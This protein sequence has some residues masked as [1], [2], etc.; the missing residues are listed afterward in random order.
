ME[1]DGT[2]MTKN[3]FLHIFLIF[4]IINLLGCK[5][6]TKQNA[7][8]EQVDIFQNIIKNNELK[9]IIINNSVDYF[10]YKGTPM[11]FHYELIKEYT[12]DFGVSLTLIVAP[13]YEN[14]LELLES[15]EGHMLASNV[16]ITGSRKKRMLFSEPFMRSNP[17]LVQNKESNKQ[18]IEDW[19]DTDTIKITIPKESASER[20]IQNIEENLG[21]C[22][23]TEFYANVDQEQLIDMVAEDS[24]AST[25]ADKLVAKVAKT[26]YPQLDISIN[27]GLPHNMA[28]AINKN[29]VEL[30][31]NIND[32]INVFRKSK[33]YRTLY[34]KYF[35][36]KKSIVRNKEGKL[37]S[38]KALSRYDKYI[39]KEA[40]I[41]NW[42]WR[43]LAA[44]IYTE[45]RFDHSQVSWAG[46]F[47][48]MQMMPITAKNFGASRHSSPQEQ[49]TAGRKYLQYL[50]EKFAQDMIERKD[51]K[52]FVLASYNSGSGHIL[53]A[54]EL[55]KKEGKDKDSW[56]EVAPYVTLLNKPKYYNDKVVKHGYFRGKETINHVNRV[57]SIYQDYKNLFPKE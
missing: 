43:L 55:A 52:L 47:G 22:I 11:G 5:Q 16:N 35:R 25:L 31:R 1:S 38:T 23:N 40:K 18:Y 6:E 14:A 51:L 21:L 45:S 7:Q 13:D 12:K 54:R 9:V 19:L 32:W 49:L 27:A 24:I 46:A 26:Y 8:Q 17:V 41:L 44:L 50:E 53:D 28:W 56:S 2:S 36:N 39:K 15:G 42:D 3:T 57:I 30:Q 34:T 48:L 29:G 10:T 33:K 4:L 20:I 37:A